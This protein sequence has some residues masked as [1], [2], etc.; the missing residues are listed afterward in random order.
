MLGS[1][2]SG[3]EYSKNG[4]CLAF[5]VERNC[6][7]SLRHLS[8]PEYPGQ[9]ASQAP[10]VYATWHKRVAGAR[11]ELSRHILRNT[12]LSCITLNRV[13]S[14]DGASMPSLAT[15]DVMH[16]PACT[17]PAPEENACGKFR[18]LQIRSLSHNSLP[19]RH[20]YLT[21]SFIYAT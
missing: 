1:T 6:L 14:A 11:Q 4:A 21:S 12:L 18:C 15:S 19:L 10:R 9:T 7:P 13:A 5:G 3:V 8:R 17:R 20:T 16:S 2:S